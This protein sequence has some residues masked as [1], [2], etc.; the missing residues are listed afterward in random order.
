[1]VQVGYILGMDSLELIRLRAAID[2]I[3][4][5]IVAALAKRV[6]RSKKIGELKN[7]VGG[8]IV[9]EKRKKQLIASR[10]ALGKKKGLSP[11]LIREVFE[12][13]HKDSVKI[14]KKVQL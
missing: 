13:I 14:Q 3:D 2:K 5:Y 11:V 1:M 6:V 9:D 10:V 7:K 4:S 8:K 12:A